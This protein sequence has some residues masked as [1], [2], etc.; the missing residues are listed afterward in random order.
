MKK[1]LLIACLVMISFGAFAQG[2]VGFSFPVPPK[3]KFRNNNLPIIR[4]ECPTPNYL[5]SHKTSPEAMAAIALTGT[6][7]TFLRGL[8]ELSTPP[9]PPIVFPEG[10][11]GTV[12][13]K[14]AQPVVKHEVPITIV[15]IS[16]AAYP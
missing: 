7:A 6:I 4:T 5:P 15:P 11:S 9:P 10:I 14:E 3:E 16:V 1:I 13:I 8:E 2:V 12:I